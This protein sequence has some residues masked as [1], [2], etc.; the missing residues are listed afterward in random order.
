MQFIPAID[1]KDGKCVRLHKGLMDDCKQYALDAS[2]VIETYGLAA[3]KHLHIVDLD[4]AINGFPCNSKFIEEIALRFNGYMQVGG[5]VRTLKDVKFYLSMGMTRVVLGTSVLENPNFT[6]DV[7]N[8]YPGRICVSVDTVGKFVATRGWMNVSKIRF[9][10]LCDVLSKT[11]AACLLWTNVNRDGTLAGL[12][13]QLIDYII[14]SCPIPV[15]VS[16]GV[17]SVHDLIELQ[18]EFSNSLAGVVCGKAI[19]EKAFPLNIANQIFEA[20]IE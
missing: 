16:G 19:Y 20:T 7:C 6:L 18:N 12:D 15:V 3:A 4:G 14:K 9:D 10:E 11:A 1:I 17:A 5:G 2:S 13:F 8:Q